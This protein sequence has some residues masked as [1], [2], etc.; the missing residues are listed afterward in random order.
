MKQINIKEIK[1][2]DKDT[3][4]TKVVRAKDL[5]DIIRSMLEDWQESNYYIELS[6]KDYSKTYFEKRGLDVTG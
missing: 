3:H 1:W 6:L 4:K 2:V 5:P